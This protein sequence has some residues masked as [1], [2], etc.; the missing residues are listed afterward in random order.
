MTKKLAL[1]V[2]LYVTPEC[3]LSC[4][5]CYYDAL[6]RVGEPD[7]ILT[8]ERMRELI[9]GLCARFDADISVEGG[10]MFLR[11]GMGAMLASLPSEVLKHLTVTTNGT[12]AIDASDDVL[13]AVGQLRI[14]ADGHTDEL[15]KE[16]RG[17]GLRPIMRTFH[18]L[19]E[20]DVPTIIRKTIWRKNARS[21]QEIYAWA[22]LENVDRL[23]LFEYQSS[24]RGIL[25]RDAYSLSPEDFEVFIDDL[26]NIPVPSSF[27]RMTLNLNA[28]RV[29]A[30]EE[31]EEALLKNGLGVERLQDVPNCTI[32]FDGTVGISPW[33]VTAHGAAD[34]FTHTEAP[35]VFD[36]LEAAAR[37]G[38][39]TD[40][41]PNISR[42]KVS[43]LD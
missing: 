16:L 13:A 25:S 36:Q 27:K 19:R 3:N 1:D 15:N 10:E 41:T 33:R 39:L 6:D 5:H 21:L 40:E 2:H 20:R 24:G 38:E 30:V 17:V 37:S 4:P 35:D 9:E 28:G 12:V 32:N 42:V 8:L 11:K 22:E 29:Q 18:K 31:R 34:V 14:S 23:A 43:A 26:C 7:G